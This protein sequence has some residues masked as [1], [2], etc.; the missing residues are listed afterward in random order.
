[1][2]TIGQTRPSEKQRESEEIER[3]TKEFFE[4]DGAIK[5]IPT[6]QSEWRPTWKAYADSAFQER[7]EGGE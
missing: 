4:R 2:P 6:Q 3:L 7:N 1:M 5:E